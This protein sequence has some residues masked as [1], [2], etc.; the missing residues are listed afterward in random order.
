MDHMTVRAFQRVAAHFGI[1]R[2]VAVL[3]TRAMLQAN[4]DLYDARSLF[5][6]RTSCTEDNGEP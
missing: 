3:M 6:L 1:D 5:E 4:P 2:G